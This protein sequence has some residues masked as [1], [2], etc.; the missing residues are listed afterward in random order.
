MHNN[1]LTY[2]WLPSVLTFNKLTSQTAAI[3]NAVHSALGL[4]LVT[5]GQVNPYYLDLNDLDLG[6]APFTRDALPGMAYCGPFSNLSYLTIQYV[7]LIVAFGQ[8]AHQMDDK[9]FSDVEGLPVWFEITDISAQVPEGLPD[10]TYQSGSPQNPT[11]SIHTWETW[12]VYGDSHKP[13][14]IGTKYYR[15]NCIGAAGNKLNASVW[16][17]LN[18]TGALKV[19]NQSQY[20]A[21]VDANQPQL[22]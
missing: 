16:V 4:P 5:V 8:V 7:S 18:N 19:L 14:L 6:G 2:V 22:P 9:L 12:G 3:V 13:Q 21:I 15:T 17:P 10:R 1:G 20:Q 11:T